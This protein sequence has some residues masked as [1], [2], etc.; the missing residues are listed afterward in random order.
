MRNNW[1]EAEERII[2]LPEDDPDSFDVYRHWIYS[3]AICSQGETTDLMETNKEWYL[4]AD[5]YILG[6]KLQDADFKDAVLDAMIEK[7]EVEKTFQTRLTLRLY[8]GT[9]KGSLIRQ[10]MVDMH[11]WKAE[12]SWFAEHY[13]PHYDCESLFDIA[14]AFV[15]QGIKKT[16]AEKPPFMKDRCLYHEHTRSGTPCYKTKT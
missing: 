9:P 8:K 15:K 7:M 5:S 4:L 12:D 10:F 14:A 3:R 11:V 13:R 16:S 1:A 2:R 6:E